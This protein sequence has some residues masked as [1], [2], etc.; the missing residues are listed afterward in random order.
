MKALLLKGNEQTHCYGTVV[1]DDGR[2]SLELL[3]KDGIEDRYESM[4]V[5]FDELAAEQLEAEL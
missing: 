2:V 5:P 1:D 4:I 3:D